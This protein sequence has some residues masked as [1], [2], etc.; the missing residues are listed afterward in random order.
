[1]KAT[2]KDNVI[3]EADKNDLIYRRQLVFPA[4]QCQNRIF[5]QKRDAVHLSMER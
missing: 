3:A 5:A 4:R 2:W 1:M